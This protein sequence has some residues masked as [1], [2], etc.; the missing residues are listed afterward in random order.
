MR[1][2]PDLQEPSWAVH[3]TPGCNSQNC[4]YFL[5]SVQPFMVH[6]TAA[7]QVRLGLGLILTLQPHQSSRALV[8]E[9]Q[10]TRQAL[11]GCL[12]L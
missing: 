2:V 9:G 8:T 11:T 12:L 6:F 3:L 1:A 5:Q 10:E 4:G 7:V